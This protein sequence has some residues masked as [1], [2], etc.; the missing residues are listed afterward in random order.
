[1]IDAL[2]EYKKDY[3]KC[4]VPLRWPESKQL[5]QWVE[6][7]SKKCKNKSLSE[8]HF[9]RLDNVGFGW[10]YGLTEERGEKWEK[11]FVE[12]RKYKEK[13]GDCNVP[14]RWVENDLKLG[15]WV[16]T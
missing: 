13:H 15:R 4:N 5:G 8:Y 14:Y 3:G 2:Q 7:Q 10:K 1:M 12:L 16:M 9:K 6:L 11:M